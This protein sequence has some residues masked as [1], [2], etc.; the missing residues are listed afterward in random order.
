[1]SVLARTGLRQLRTHRAQTFLSA[2][3]IAL[4]VAVVLSV[5]L[6]SGSARRAFTISAE[7]V[8]GAATHHVTGAT[9]GVPDSLYAHLRSAL[10][11]RSMAPVV[12][13]WVA[14]PDGRTLR[15][16]GIDP[17]AEPA[18]RPD[19]GAGRVDVRQLIAVPGAAA[20]TAELAGS[21]G[22]AVGEVLTIESGGVT[23][24]LPVVGVLE[25][26]DA[27]AAQGLADVLVVDIAS[28]QEVL[29]QPGRL[30]R[31]DLVL[32]GRRGERAGAR[33]AAV[34]PPDLRL[35]TAAA[36]TAAI[37]GMTRAF[38]L[39]LAALGLL[40]LVFGTFLIYNAATFSV[41]RRRPLIATL[42]A[43]GV[44]RREVL[45]L[46]L[47]EAAL[48]GVLGT[49]VGL[50]LGTALGSALVHLVTRTINDLYF[51]VNVRALHLG[52]SSF[53][54]AGVLGVGATL[55]GALPAAVEAANTAPH[56]ASIRSTLE[57]RVRRGL[58]RL[59]GAGVL[60]LAAGAGLIALPTTAA[61]PAFAGL[62]ALILGVAALAPLATRLFALLLRRLLG[63][64]G[65][66]GRLA[67]GGVAAALSRTAPAVAALAV[68]VAVGIA[69]GVM[70][71]SFRASVVDWLDATLQGDLYVSAPGQLATRPGRTLDPGA[72]AAARAA[73]GV[74]GATAFR[75]VDVAA[76]AGAVRLIAIDLDA[77]HRAAFQFLD[78]APAVWPE[79]AAG[80]ILVS[81]PFAYRHGAG[82][83]STVLL[84]GPEGMARFPVAG[85]FRDYASEQGVLFIDR[86][87][88]RRTWRDD[89]LTSLALYLTADADP[90]ATAAA[91]QGATQQRLV[92]RS[93][94]GL[95][96]ATLDVFER[97]F[98]ITGVLRWLAIA[99]AF[100]GV[101][102]AL[103]ALQL[104][105][106]REAAVLR[107]L[108]LTPRQLGAL[109]GTQT[110]VI[111]G[112]AALIAVPLG[113]ALALV[114]ILVVNRRS[115]GWT[116]EPVLDPWLLAQGALLA[117]LA[118]LLAA[119]YPA[120]RLARS[121][122]VE[123]LRSE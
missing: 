71:G 31:I 11:I 9:A 117:L 38:D 55:L 92:I 59:T 73:P 110:A 12:E 99:V 53:L 25:P 87:V 45:A 77:R 54:T 121:R 111:G 120:W 42:R 21:L 5:D 35:E 8:A 90:L 85:V 40:A 70:I 115:F 28:A 43:L 107:S 36:R 93:N 29:G 16:L 72:V 104:E 17:F 33:I 57:S 64:A 81:E 83:G 63:A 119:P 68:A 122:P 109:V 30:T 69:V 65:P 27:L 91:I 14:G 1:V 113:L 23:H 22:A 74:A 50:L 3:G 48:V 47:G 13:G 98:A 61:L 32:E 105:R 100:T 34:L 49:A 118:A 58:G 51:V 62:F 82:V 123:G 66:V 106:A 97:T 46:V 80:A 89:A 101:L 19:L 41:L 10:G 26:G 18:V 44:T 94:A 112:I 7:A 56:V 95:R 24:A 75:H 67:A 15:L 6:A 84:P 102:G 37:T 96:A 88:Y 116:M 79:F 78:A 39:N 114:M 20:L 86:D 2:L 4:G 52:A 76:G 108:G 60:L 103:L